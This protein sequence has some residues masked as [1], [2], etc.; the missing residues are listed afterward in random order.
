MILVTG[1]TGLVGSHLLYHLLQKEERIRAIHLKSSDLQRVKN[2]FSYYGNSAVELFNNIDWVEADLNH[3]PGLELAFKG[4]KKVYHCAAMISFN[5][6]DYKRMR[7]VNIEGTT[8]IVNICISNQIEKLCF[9]SS[10][11]AIENERKGVLVDETKH[12]NSTEEKSGYSITKYGAELEVWRASQEGVKVVIVNPG[13]ILGSGFWNKGSGQMFSQIDRGLRFY[14]EGRTGFVSVQD[15]VR[16]MIDL[17]NSKISDDRFI[18]VSENLSFKKVFTTIARSLD[19]EVPSFKLQKWMMAVLWR[20]EW[21][22]HKVF[23]HSPKVTKFSAKSSFADHPYSSDKIKKHLNI[24][25]TPIHK[26]I[27]LIAKDYLSD[28]IKK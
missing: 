22:R 8:N 28:Q 25:F 2:V 24:Q 18:L 9:V 27:Q 21:L 12:W 15:V 19:K 26:S 4:V 11:A 6:S 23:A 13:I 10:V 7:R 5:P 14:T 3:L 17:M 20:V 16:I 1:G